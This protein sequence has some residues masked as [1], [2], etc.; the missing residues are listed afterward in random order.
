LAA[1]QAAAREALD[2]YDWRVARQLAPV[3]KIASMEALRH[4][5]QSL[6]DSQVVHL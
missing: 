2:A 1:L 3:G 5:L 6:E 4:A